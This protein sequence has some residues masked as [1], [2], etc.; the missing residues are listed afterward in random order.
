M[1]ELVGF[2]VF[3]AAV[4]AHAVGMDASLRSMLGGWMGGNV[5]IWVVAGLALGSAVGESLG[6]IASSIVWMRAMRSMSLD[7]VV[8]M[9]HGL[10]AE[11]DNID[12]SD[13]RDAVDRV[14]GIHDH[15]AAIVLRSLCN[16]IVMSSVMIYLFSL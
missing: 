6:R 8:D 15:G 14:R 7:A 1:G 2:A 16:L 3:F 13:E 12:E 10:A 11:R 5:I 9:I 4:G